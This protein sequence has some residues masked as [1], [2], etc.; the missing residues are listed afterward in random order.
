MKRPT[1][2]RQSFLNSAPLFVAL[3][4]ILVPG[5]KSKFKVFGA[6]GRR[7]T[8]WRKPGNTTTARWFKVC[9]DEL[10]CRVAP[11]Q[12]YALRDDYCHAHVKDHHVAD[13]IVRIARSVRGH[14]EEP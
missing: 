10:S 6:I 4:S 13:Q 8:P 12:L 5:Q 14:G 11:L 2:V 1:G 3:C 9:L 7:K